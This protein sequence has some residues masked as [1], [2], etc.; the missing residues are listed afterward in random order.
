MIDQ[1]RIT[2]VVLVKFALKSL[3]RYRSVKSELH[4]LDVS[5]FTDI[6]STQVNRKTRTNSCK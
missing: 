6:V 4:M 1:R 5:S 3:K 2:R